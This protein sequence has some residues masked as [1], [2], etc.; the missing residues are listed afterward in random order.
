MIIYTGLLYFSTFVR[1]SVFMKMC[2][3]QSY[4]STL[5]DG[6]YYKYTQQQQQIQHKIK[7]TNSE[8]TNTVDCIAVVLLFFF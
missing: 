2:V 4:C 3:I 1:I 5:T 6:N 7:K 8:Y